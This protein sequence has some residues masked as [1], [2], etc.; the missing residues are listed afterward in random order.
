MRHKH[1]I[2]LNCTSNDTKNLSQLYPGTLSV[3]FTKHPQNL[4]NK[5]FT[6]DEFADV[7]G[8]EIIGRASTPVHDVFILTLTA[9]LPAPVCQVQVVV[10]DRLAHLTVH[11]QRVEKRL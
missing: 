3:N 4:T 9:L 6:Y 1:N 8:E 10:D 11:Q 5:I 7:R 2:T